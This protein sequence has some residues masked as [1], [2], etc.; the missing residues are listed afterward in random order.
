MKM[1]FELNTVKYALKTINYSIFNQIWGVN[2]KVIGKN[3]FLKNGY[4]PEEI[5]V[6]KWSGPINF[7]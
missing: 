2:L 5:Y 1:K 6:C 4:N 7:A 3:N